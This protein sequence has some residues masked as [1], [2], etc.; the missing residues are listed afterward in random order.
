MDQETLMTI[1][2]Y[3][4]FF[5]ILFVFII[6]YS[7]AYSIYKRQRTGER[8]YEKYS[9]LVHDDSID[10]TPLEKRDK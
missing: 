9:K 6:F 4:K 5:I 10:S 8:D 7:Y 1:T 3:G 2:G